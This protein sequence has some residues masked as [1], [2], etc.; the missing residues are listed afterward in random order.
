MKTKEIP[1]KKK[2]HYVWSY[3]LKQWERNKKV[4]FRTQ[5]NNISQER[6]SG[7]SQ[8]PNFYKINPLTMEDIKY[9]EMWPVSGSD[10]LKDFQAS[11]LN[12]FATISQVIL[13][14][15]ANERVSR[16]EDVQHIVQALT[17]NSL[18]NT[19]AIIEGLA[20]PVIKELAKGNGDCLSKS[21]N[22]VSFC[23]FIG[24]QLIRTRKLKE[25]MFEAIHGLGRNED[26]RKRFTELFKKN[27][28]FLSYKLG[29]NIGHNL[30]THRE[31]ENHIFIKNETNIDFITTDQPIINIHDSVR[32]SGIGSPPPSEMDIYYPISPR[33]AYIISKSDR[34]NHLRHCVDPVAVQDLNTRMAEKA[35]IHIYGT[36]RESL[37][38]LVIR[39]I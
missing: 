20:L 14:S 19:H 7:L 32:Y 29:I 38:G 36:S 37:K 11:Q 34:F 33:Y 31:L 35:H 22:M 25:L 28:W 24:H 30:F 15:Q 8:L 39:R 23:N 16:I 21:S 26:E 10:S 4:W 17:S 27:W 2:H 9:I 3:Y 5:K 13:L 6:A 12:F 1:I 18:E